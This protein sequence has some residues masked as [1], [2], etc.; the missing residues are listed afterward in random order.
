[1]T[2]AK[3]GQRMAQN[4]KVDPREKVAGRL[5]TLGV[6]GVLIQMAKRGQLV[7]LRCEMPTCYCPKG[8]R[9]FD[10]WPS[11]RSS[12]KNAWAP[13]A[14]HYPKLKKDGGQLRPWNVR[15]AH[16][17]CNNTDFGW[18]RRIRRMLE[19]DPN[20]SFEAIA[21]ALN[22]KKRIHRPPKATTWTAEIVRRAYVS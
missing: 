4:G 10:A 3:E 6:G 13:N 9:H 21:V 14:D 19:K 1:M 12:A 5:K 16:V 15:L 11:P 18:R 2:G 7:E 20:V 22:R 17:S 8:R